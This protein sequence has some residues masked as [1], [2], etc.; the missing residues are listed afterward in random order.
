MPQSGLIHRLSH[1]A[2]LNRVLVFIWWINVAF[3]VFMLLSG[4]FV[5]STTVVG[6]TLFVS[7]LVG[8][9]PVGI[10]ALLLWLFMFAYLLTNDQS[11]LSAKIVWTCLLVIGINV[12]AYLYFW[13]VY[14][15]DVVRQPGIQA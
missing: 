5:N 2:K 8:F 6:R 1:N 3:T 14:R 15:R 11:A 10:T 12:A 4:P 9:V 13:I 7:L